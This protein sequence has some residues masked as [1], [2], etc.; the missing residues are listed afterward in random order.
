MYYFTQDLLAYLINMTMYAH[1]FHNALFSIH[2][3]YVTVSQCFVFNP[4]NL[5]YVTQI[6]EVEDKRIPTFVLIVHLAGKEKSHN[7]QQSTEGWLVTRTIPEFNRLHEQLI[8]VSASYQYCGTLLGGSKACWRVDYSINN[9]GQMYCFT[10]WPIAEKERTAVCEKIHH[11]GWEI[12]GW[13]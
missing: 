11:F 3:L 4:F 7:L 6:Q 2:L 13:L 1:K 9:F 12:P 8:E 5:L 10:D